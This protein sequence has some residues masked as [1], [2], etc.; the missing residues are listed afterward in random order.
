MASADRP[1]SGSGERG[2]LA[3]GTGGGQS[4]AGP[5]PVRGATAAAS[6]AAR[7]GEI[8]VFSIAGTISTAP[9]DDSQV[10]DSS[11]CV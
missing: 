3:G 10:S 1:I 2:Q 7:S 4:P 8:C 9:S 5:P 11:C 6:L